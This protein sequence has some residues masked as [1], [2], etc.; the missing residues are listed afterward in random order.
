MTIK[1][2]LALASFSLLIG[3]ATTRVFPVEG[4]NL[5]IVVSSDSLSAGYASALKEIKSYC[6]ARSLEYEVIQ[7]S[8]EYVGMDKANKAKVAASDDL[9]R[10]IRE[11]SHSGTLD[12][13]DDNRVTM[14][15]RC[16]AAVAMTDLLPTR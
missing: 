3:C 4:G 9:S 12:R 15:F 2:M 1:N 8:G 11:M 5:K 14:T 7:D 10:D 13:K 6:G 16:K